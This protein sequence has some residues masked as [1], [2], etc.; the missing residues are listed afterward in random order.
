MKILN[1]I[2][3]THGLRRT[4]RTR[5]QE[6]VAVDGVNLTVH[7]GEVFGFL[8]PNGAGKTTTLRMLAT[9]LEPSGGDATVAGASV[10]GNPQQV[11]R[12]LGYMPDSFG[13]YDDMRVWEYLDFFGRC[14]GLSAAQ[15]RRMIADLLELVDLGP[16]RN[17]YV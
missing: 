15:R 12:V 14:Y 6:V 10:R 8:G 13:V 17:A 11:R 3:E 4:F 2:I 9:L 16:K 7:R 5:K 1:P